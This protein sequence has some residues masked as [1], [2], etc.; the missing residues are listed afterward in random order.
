MCYRKRVK[1]TRVRTTDFEGRTEFPRKRQTL[2]TNPS[3][4]ST[5]LCVHKI[6]T[7][8]KTLRKQKDRLKL[9]TEIW[10]I[11]YVATVVRREKKTRHICPKTTGFFDNSF[12]AV[13]MFCFWRQINSAYSIRPQTRKTS[14]RHRRPRRKGFSTTSTALPSIY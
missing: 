14:R 6:F 1:R 10:K 12:L 8:T 2:K 9:A 4:A 3:L 5:I 7:Q 11:V 13:T